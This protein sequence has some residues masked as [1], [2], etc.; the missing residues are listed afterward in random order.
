MDGK[1]EA[2]EQAALAVRVARL[3]YHQ[4]LTSDAVA[5][6]LG[7]S[8]PK[9]SR[10]LGYARKTG[11][12]EIR[13]HD[14]GVPSQ[15]LAAEL[16][17]RYPFLSAQV[18]GVPVG[19]GEEVWLSRVA[20]ACAALLGTL[21]QAG[22]VVGLAWGNTLDA[23][24]REL[25]PRAIPDLSFV[26]L[27]GSAND[28]DLVSGFVSETMLRFA[29]NYSAKAY[30]F[31]VP[32]F[33]DDPVTKEA[34]WRERSVR[35]V[36]ELQ[37]RADLLLYSVGSHTARTPSHVYSAGYLDSADLA[38]LAAEGAV[39]DIATVFFR[40]DGSHAGLALNA[41]ASGP[42]LSLIRRAA[43]ALCVVSGLGKAA[44]LHAAL[45][46]RLLHRLI[47]DEMTAQAVLN[48]GEP[49]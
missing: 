24:S 46:G 2:D 22:Q 5:R 39:G 33:F 20:T 1:R 9:V 44:A 34:M 43:D 13:I 16:Q 38:S 21:L 6:E 7:L 47:V 35:H 48:R 3:Y 36:L 29:R 37:E 45:E 49:R 41:R 4:G 28:S 14:A 40:A 18:V 32:T 11:L 23:V 15:A 25:L 26:Q 10:L 17:R 19:S 30:L 31:P 8:R 42:D 12:V 27:N